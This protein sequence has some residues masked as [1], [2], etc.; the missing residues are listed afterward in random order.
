[1]KR[2]NK[3][4]IR[5]GLIPFIRENDQIYMMFMR[6]ADPKYGGD[7]LQIA[8]GKVD[9]GENPFDAAVREGGEELGVTQKNIKWIKK[10]GIFLKTHHIYIAEM[11]SNDK[12][13]FTIPHFETSE[14]EWVT[15]EE[16]M[17]IGRDLHKPIVK[18]SYDSFLLNSGEIN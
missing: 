16:F 1:M 5:A 15:L 13:L 8:K 7:K 4:I 6:P 17:K 14:T 11:H 12:N 3:P 18:S 9:P 2:S 10:V